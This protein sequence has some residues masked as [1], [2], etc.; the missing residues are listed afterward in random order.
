MRRRLALVALFV[1]LAALLV[2]GLWWY[3]TAPPR[4]RVASV[5]RGPAVD[6]IY[7]TGTVEP[8]HWAQI[9]PTLTGRI[10]DY[11]A[12]EGQSVA[13]GDLLVRLDDTEA[14]AELERLEAQVAFLERDVER[15]AALVERENVSR[16][17][18]DRV[19]RDLR[20]A[21]AAAAVARQKLHDMT[22][23][24][25]IDGSVLRKDGEVGEVVKAGDV[26]LTV[27]SGRP[28]WITAE[29]DEEDIPRVLEDQV[30][31]I[32]AD[33]FAGQVLDGA[34][35]EITPM[36]DPINK[37]YRVRVLLPV[38]SP[39]LIG[40]TTE[41]N[42]VARA[43]EQALLIPERALVDGAVW[44]VESGAARRRAVEIGVYGD[45]VIEVRGGL[46]DGA[47]VILNP[48]LTL[49]DGDPVKI[50]KD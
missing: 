6:A 26:L 16:Q 42:I 40:M 48:P 17:T 7:A 29:V 12:V 46:N 37:Q 9:A 20:Q 25:P 49:E 41:V 35:T 11:P 5:T 47:V 24:S 10:V 23:L 19:V 30:A 3:E 39:L 45:T 34:V 31:L 18:Y 1:G 33:A 14:R 50:R 32:T 22:I 38:D 15:Y 27:G 2:G 8:I 44:T 43:D 4:V 13:R 28:Y 21:R 36:G